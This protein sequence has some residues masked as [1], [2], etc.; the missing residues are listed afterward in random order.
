M[1]GKGKFV[2]ERGYIHIGY[3]NLAEA[4]KVVAILMPNE[5]T[6]KRLRHRAADEGRLLD[7]T[8]GHKIR[9]IIV[10]ASNHVILSAM[11][12]E[13][14]W[15]RASGNIGGV[16]FISYTTREDLEREGA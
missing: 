2:P 14:L 11:T 7:A 4:S 3:G 16:P 9:A 8:R 13:T 5:S 15:Q 6:M 12:P 1:K 10:T